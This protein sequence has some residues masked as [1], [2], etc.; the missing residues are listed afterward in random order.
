MENDTPPPRQ[1]KPPIDMDLVRASAEERAIGFLGIGRF[2]FEFSQLEFTIR[3]ELANL[4]E[5]NDDAF[6]IVTSPYD[7]TALCNVTCKMRCLKS[8]KRKDEFEKLFNACRELNNTRV[9]VAH[10]M[11]VDDMDGLSARHVS[12]QTLEAKFH[13]FKNDELERFAAEAQRLLKAVLGFQ[14]PGNQ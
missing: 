13:S 4:L 1:P 7:F 10:G 12:R 8:P 2:L 9:I 6:D 14:P 5:L 3:V 11:W